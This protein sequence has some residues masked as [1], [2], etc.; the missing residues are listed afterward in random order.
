MKKVIIIV[1]GGMDSVTLL[2]EVVKK[3]G[4]KNVFALSFAYGSRHMKKEIPM[5]QF[6]CKKLGVSHQIVDVRGVFKNFNSALLDKKDSEKIPEGHYEAANMKKTIVPFRNGILLSIAAGFA[7]TNGAKIL[8]YGAHAG[9]HFI[10]EDCRKEF[11][12]AM[13]Q[14]IKLG[15]MNAIEIKAPYWNDTKISILKK[16]KKLGVDYSKTWT[17]Y[18]PKGNRQPCGRCGADMERVEAFLKN[19]LVDPLYTPKNWEKAV[20]YY[21]SFRKN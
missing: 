9:D 15:T 13:S 12:D 7:E 16:G 10:Y 19:N 14:A 1:S 17:C 8:Y 6:N 11:V 2:H 18:N 3:H 5:A 4:A 21:E 20:E